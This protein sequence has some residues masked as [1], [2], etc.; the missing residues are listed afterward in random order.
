[1]AIQSLPSRLLYH[2]SGIFKKKFNNSKNPQKIAHC[3]IVFIDINA[4]FVYNTF[5]WIA[6]RSEL[7]YKYGLPLPSDGE[8]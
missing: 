2:K 1:M 7:V 5:V 3:Q 4:G 8:S 6:Y